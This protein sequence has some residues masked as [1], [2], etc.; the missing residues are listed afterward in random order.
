[1][2]GTPGPA[3]NPAAVRCGR[4]GEYCPYL[5]FTHIL[6]GDSR[7]RDSPTVQSSVLHSLLG[8]VDCDVLLLHD[9]C[10]TTQAGEAFTGNGVV[11]TLAAGGIELAS[12][13]GSSHSFT[14]SLVQEL[15]RAAHTTDWLSAVELHRRLINRL[16]AWTPTVSFA[17]DAY[18]L[19]QID[20]RTGQPMLE[21]P[22]RRTPIHSFLSKKPK[23]IVLTPLPPQAQRQSEDS[24]MLLQPPTAEDEAVPE[25]PG[26]LVTCRLR[27]QHVDVERWRQWLLKAPEAARGIQISALYPGFSAVLI[28]ELPLVVWDLLPPLPAISFIAYTTGKNHI[29]DFRRALLGSDGDESPDTSDD[30]SDEDEGSQVTKHKRGSRAKSRRDSHSKGTPVVSSLWPRLFESDRTALYAMEDVPYCLNFAEMQR[31]DNTSKAEKIIRTFVQETDGPSTRY[32]CDEIQGFC[33][34]A[35]FEALSA[36]QEV[37]P[38]PVAILDERSLSGLD[39]QANGMRILTRGQLYEALISVCSPLNLTYY[40]VADKMLRDPSLS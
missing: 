12:H 37:A 22:S 9:C 2:A 4:R 3:S 32:I 35:S 39:L 13:E 36:D 5:L 19:V 29:S 11:E 28:V 6:T 14:T 40:A 34:P 23:T 33:A 8:E 18:S 15:S 7:S 17:D 31:D 16:Q 10:H 1:M 24:F 38:E 27:D 26:I 30:E 21:R 25:G 20:R